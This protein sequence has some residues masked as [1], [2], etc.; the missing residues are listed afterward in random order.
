M[1]PRVFGEDERAFLWLLAAQGGQ[2]IER[3]QLLSTVARFAPIPTIGPGVVL[4]RRERDVLERVVDGLTNREI[5]DQLG[6]GVDTIKT[7]VA[8]ICEKLDVAG[9]SRSRVLAVRAIRLGLVATSSS[10]Q[11]AAAP[12][13][14]RRSGLAQA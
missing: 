3:V 8:H 9:S 2:A 12:S 14:S 10:R 6:L 13:R 4:S 5:A 11:P 1:G 7:H